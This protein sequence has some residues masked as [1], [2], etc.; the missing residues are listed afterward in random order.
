[1]RKMQNYNFCFCSPASSNMCKFAFLMNLFLIELYFVLTLLHLLKLLG[2]CFVFLVIMVDPYWYGVV[3][4][5]HRQIREGQTLDL[6]P[7]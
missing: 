1:M 2:Q 5:K 3:A 6:F 4:K 7:C